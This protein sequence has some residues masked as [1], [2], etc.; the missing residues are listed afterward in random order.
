MLEYIVLV[1]AFFSLLSVSIYIRSMLKGG[2]KPNRIS[3][4][5][6]AIAPLIATAAAISSGVTWAV[7]PVF[8]SGFG[9]V[10]VFI[11]SFAIKKSYWKLTRF[12]YTCGILS[13]LALI[14]WYVT[15]DANVAI[16]FSILSD[17]LASIPTLTKAWAHPETESGWPYIIGLF[18]SFTAFVVITAVTFSQIGFPVYLLV[19]NTML[20]LSVYNKKISA[21]FKFR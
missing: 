16:L 5:M 18:N 21:W 11:A 1:A 2:C 15:K 3:W 19:M 6:W 13:A 14:L 12:D 17:G 8:M 20:C 4:L 9:P 10:L 7:I